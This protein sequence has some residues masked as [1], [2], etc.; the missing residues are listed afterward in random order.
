MNAFEEKL[1]RTWVQL[2][3]DN[4]YSEIAAIAL[5]TEV[6]V[7][8]CGYDPEFI[9]F[10][11]P[12]SSY[13]YVKNNDQIK[14]LM[15]RAML[16][17]SQGHIYDNNGETVDELPFRYRVKLIEVE[18][19]WQNIIKN[20]IVN[21]QDP[22]QALISEKVR[23]R[24]NKQIYMYNEMKFASHSEIRIAQELETRKI[25]FFPLALGVRADTGNFYN[26]HRELDF[27]I[28]QDG[29]WGILEVSH[30]PDRYEKDSEKDSWFKQS[31]ILCVQHYSAERCYSSSKAVIDEFLTILAKHKR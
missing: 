24:K 21:A 10:D 28:C 25:L 23:A 6:S 18:E 16:T 26:D 8:Y 4:N 19:G 9:A 1:H 2:L 3:T 7:S 14:K 15:E 31:G 11:I 5:E 20:L 30:H 12:T 17:V 13:V 27:L 29:T 22:N